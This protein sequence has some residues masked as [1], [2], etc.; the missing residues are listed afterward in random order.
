MWRISFKTLQRLSVALVVILSLCRTLVLVRPLQPRSRRTPLTLVLIYIL[1]QTLESAALFPFTTCEFMVRD[2]FCWESGDN[3]VVWKIS[4]FLHMASLGIPMVLILISF[5][6]TVTTLVR[7]LRTTNGVAISARSDIST[8]STI[9][10][11][12]LLSAT[13][14]VLTMTFIYM[15][16]NIPVCVLYCLYLT[17]ITEYSYPGRYFST[18]F[19][20]H[21]SWNITEVLSVAINS[22]VNP[23]V[24]YCRITLYRHWLKGR[25]AVYIHWL[26]GR[27]AVYRHW[28]E[29]RVAACR[30]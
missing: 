4:D 6:L 26:K 2:A 3:V 30:H 5:P 7:S 8:R 20:Y 25:V 22:A 11:R 23:W 10:Q 14:T 12:R 18:W 24:Y 9:P 15:A 28:M 29:G 1:Y 13:Y 21:Y 27:V 19:M 16:F 17:P